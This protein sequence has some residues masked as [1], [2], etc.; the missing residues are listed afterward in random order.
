MP[1]DWE[2]L[3]KNKFAAADKPPIDWPTGVHPISMEGLALFGIGPDNRLYWDGQS[4]KIERTVSLSW[5]QGF[6]AALAAFGTATS[7]V[8]ALL[9]YLGRHS[10]G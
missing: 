7:G 10:A 3:R 4:I 1:K 2:Q 5:W 6:L 9:T 8:V